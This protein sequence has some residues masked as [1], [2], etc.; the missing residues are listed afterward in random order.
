MNS[1]PVLVAHIFISTK[2]FRKIEQFQTLQKTL[3][4]KHILAHI[5]THKDKEITDKTLPYIYI[6]IGESP[7]LF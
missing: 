7:N 2:L 4:E 3:A 1:T 5:Y 6:S